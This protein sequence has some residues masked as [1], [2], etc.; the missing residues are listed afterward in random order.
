VTSMRGI[1][2]R[3]II[4]KHQKKSQLCKFSEKHTHFWN[5]VLNFRH[6]TFQLKR[7]RKALMQ[8]RAGPIIRIAQTVHI[9]FQLQICTK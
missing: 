9:K 6:Y 2:P 5:K 4:L 8:S 3:L 7:K 1:V